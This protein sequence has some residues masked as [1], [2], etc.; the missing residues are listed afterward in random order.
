V[1]L[2]EKSGTGIGLDFCKHAIEKQCGGSLVARNENDGA[3]F[4]IKLP[5]V[6][7]SN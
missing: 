1:T 3:V 5:K 7:Q 6:C 2:D 4:E